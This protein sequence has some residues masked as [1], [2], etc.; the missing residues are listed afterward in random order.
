MAPELVTDHEPAPRWHAA[1]AYD[2]LGPPVRQLPEPAKLDVRQ[3]IDDLGGAD[4]VRVLAAAA[5]SA[6]GG[7]FELPQ[8]LRLGLGAAQF[9]AARAAFLAALGPLDPLG[10]SDVTRR[11]V[12]ADRPLSADERRL[13][14]DR[15]PHHGS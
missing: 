10:S 2:L 12:L 9:A 11:P 7:P 13:L 3:L 15:P 1:L 5:K 14:A 4:A 8:E 6:G